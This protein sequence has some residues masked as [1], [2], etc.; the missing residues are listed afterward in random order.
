MR[1]RTRHGT[2]N[3]P[4]VQAFG[5]GFHV[6]SAGIVNAD[7]VT[8]RALF[9][10][11]QQRPFQISQRGPLLAIDSGSSGGAQVS[12][13]LA[14]EKTHPGQLHQPLPQAVHLPPAPFVVILPISAATTTAAAAAA[15]KPERPHGDAPPR[16]V[17]PSFSLVIVAVVAI[18]C[19]TALSLLLLC[20]T[21][22][23]A[24]CQPSAC[25]MHLILLYGLL[26]F[27]CSNGDQ[28]RHEI[29]QTVVVGLGCTVCLWNG[30][31]GF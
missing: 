5:L 25:V 2:R 9:R 23:E 6:R 10:V 30:L 13:C 11:D 19:I 21:R 29:N 26:L 28:L 17:P 16:T 18:K 3:A 1:P 14:V 20:P 31:E 8:A 12:L 22:R 4:F 24:A 7:R 27:D 15:V